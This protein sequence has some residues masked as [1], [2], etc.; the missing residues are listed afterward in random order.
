MMPDMEGSGNSMEENQK[1]ASNSES[2]LREFVKQTKHGNSVRQ[3]ACR[4][5]DEDRAENRS[6]SGNQDATWTGRTG[7]ENVPKVDSAE[8]KW[9]RLLKWLPGLKSLRF[10]RRSTAPEIHGGF[11]EAGNPREELP[12]TM[13]DIRNGSEQ[14]PV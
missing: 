2:V 8:K 1:P 6:I 14:R 3:K 13:W 9:W 5:Q 4:M 12:M 7:Y 11:D 10:P